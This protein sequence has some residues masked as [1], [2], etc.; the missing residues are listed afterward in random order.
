VLGFSAYVFWPRTAHLRTFNPIRV[1]QLETRM[2]R[3]YY[4]QRYADLLGDLY[5]LNRDEYGFSPADSLAIAWYAARAA[6]IFQPTRSRAEAQKALPMLERYYAVLRE[7]GGETFDEREAAR[8]E[9]D[10]WQ[11][12]RENAQPAE[13]GSVIVRTTFVVFHADNAE[14]RRAALLR[15]EMMSYRDKRRDGRMQESDWAHVES[16]L[17]RSYE[18]LR[19]GITVP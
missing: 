14:V 19:A 8:L 7:R 17:V 5:A 10:W 13:Y 6:Q 15:A 18:A 16:E 3:S 11:L 12:R 4:D 9:L 2:W 1:G